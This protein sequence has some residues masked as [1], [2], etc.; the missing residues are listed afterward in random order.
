MNSEFI[1]EP[2]LIYLNS[3]NLSLCPQRVLKAM[4]AYRREFEKN[5]SNGLADSWSHLWSVQKR[6]AQFLGADPQDLFL[7]SNVTQVLN[8]FILGVEVAP[9]SEILVGELEYGAIVNVCRLRAKRDDLKWRI[10]EMPC[11]LASVKK[12]DKNKLVDWVVSQL[13]PNTRVLLLSHVLGGTGLVLP[14]A[15]IAKHTRARSVLLIVDGAYAPGAID[16]DLRALCDV[17]FYGCSLYK[18]MVGPKGTAF[19]W[20]ARRNRHLLHPINAG[21]AT[22][23]DFA[24]LSGFGDG[25]RFQATF[26]MSGCHDFAP[27][28]AIGDTLDFWNEYGATAIRAKMEFLR[29]HLIKEIKWNPMLSDDKALNGPLIAFLLPSRLQKIG[30][31]LPKLALENFGIQLNSANLRGLWHAIFSPHVYNTPEEISRAIA[32]LCKL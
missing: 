2:G 5:P 31:A 27:F 26:L 10:L 25:D 1:K 6:L 15:E 30:A 13:G 9:H 24:P 23:E 28:R 16:V 4:D 11:S 8:T 32:L 17:D 19:G 21:W 22:F 18:W 3:A 14:I 12:L 20:V 29:E 7:R